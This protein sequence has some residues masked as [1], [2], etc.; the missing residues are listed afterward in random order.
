MT[1]PAVAMGL[2]NDAS[3]ASVKTSGCCAVLNFTAP[4]L[5]FWS[6]SSTLAATEM[7]SVAVDGVLTM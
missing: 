6:M 7:A 2:E 3:I 4:N 5:M 1:G